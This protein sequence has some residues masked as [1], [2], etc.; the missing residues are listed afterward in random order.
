[1]A[2]Q[3][4]VKKYYEGFMYADILQQDPVFFDITELPKGL[5]PG[6]HL[7]VRI[8]LS[9]YFFKIFRY[10]AVDTKQTSKDRLAPLVIGH[11]ITLL[12][13][14][15]AAAAPP[16]SEW[17]KWLGP[18]FLGVIGLT[19]AILFA[20]GYWYRRSDWRVRGRLTAARHANFIPPPPET[21]PSTEG[22][23]R[24]RLSPGPTDYSA[25]DN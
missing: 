8:G 15:K 14:P 6:D 9:G 19:V 3:G 16:D 5:E 18:A 1:M 10:T 25:S 4:G 12:P 17:V 2:L 24:N 23:P 22:E 13:E 11:T 21:P 20:V 7:N